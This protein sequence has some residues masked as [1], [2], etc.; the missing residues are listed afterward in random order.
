M[1]NVYKKESSM[2]CAELIEE[3][4]RAIGNVYW[5]LPILGEMHEDYEGSKVSL[6]KVI[7]LRTFAM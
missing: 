4:G 3:Y 7:S 5:K 1:Q 6:S 2:A